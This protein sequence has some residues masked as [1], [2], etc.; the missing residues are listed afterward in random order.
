MKTMEQKLHGNSYLLLGSAEE[1][2]ELVLLDDAKSFEEAE[3]KAELFLEDNPDGGIL[4]T[5]YEAAC[6]R[7]PLFPETQH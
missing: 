7:I 3:K 6:Y 5:K 2:G 1:G 4:I